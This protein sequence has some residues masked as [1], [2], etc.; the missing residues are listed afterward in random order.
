MN[1]VSIMMC[2]FNTVQFIKQAI[3]SVQN[4]THKNWELIISDDVSTDGTYE[5][6]SVLASKDDRIKI[7]Q[8]EKTLGTAKNR[9]A[10]SKHLTGDFVCH[11]DSDDVLERWALEEMLLHFEK[12]PEIMLM[13]SD[14]IQIGVDNE[15]QSY[16]QSKDFNRNLMHQHGWRHFGMYRSKVLKE[17]YGYNDKLLTCEDGDLFMQIAE[18]YDCFRVPKVLYYYRAH[19]KNA[20]Q[21]NSK[22]DDCTLRSDC[23]YVRVWCKS[24]KYDPVT[25]K[26]L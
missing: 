17:I 5:L 3:E 1:K 24:A 10:A 11:V 14:F 15:T 4:Q 16:S 26:P 18:K 23:N 13:Y 20:S 6:A 9:H 7:Y 19:G 2:S 22:C 8:N 25:F 21:K 12:M